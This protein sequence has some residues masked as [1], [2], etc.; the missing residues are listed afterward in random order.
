MPLYRLECVGYIVNTFMYILHFC[1]FYN[2]HTCMYNFSCC[3][4]N[5]ILQMFLF[6]VAL[7]VLLHIYE[8]MHLYNQF[9]WC[10]IFYITGFVLLWFLGLQRKTE[11][12]SI[13]LLYNIL[14]LYHNI[15]LFALVQPYFHLCPQGQPNQYFQRNHLFYY[16][17]KIE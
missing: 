7:C 4:N 3:Y 5:N 8:I 14:Y 15:D 13:P 11:S 10:N 2:I 17:V 12:H 6:P 9:S 1:Y 16:Y